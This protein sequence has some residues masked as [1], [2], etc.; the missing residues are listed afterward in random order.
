[1]S[2]RTFAVYDTRQLLGFAHERR[3][4]RFEAETSTG[5]KLG[6]FNAASGAREAIVTQAQRREPT[7]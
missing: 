5:A 2:D 4:G 3:D 1:M 6:L 7:T